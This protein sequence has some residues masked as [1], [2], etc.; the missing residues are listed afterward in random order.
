MTSTSSKDQV[1]ALISRGVELYG[2]GRLKEAIGEW[3]RAL[4][5]RPGEREAREYLKYVR[6][7]FDA[8]KS[9]FDGGHAVPLSPPKSPTERLFEEME[10]EPSRGTLEIGSG[11]LGGVDDMTLEPPSGAVDLLDLGEPGE[12]LGGSAP[13]RAK[14]PS[15]GSVSDFDVSDADGRETFDLSEME[16]APSLSASEEDQAVTVQRPS[17][18][19]FGDMA[20]TG[21]DEEP[22]TVQR[23][24]PFDMPGPAV[25]GEGIDLEM[26][27]RGAKKGFPIE[28]MK[29]TEYSDP[30]PIDIGLEPLGAAEQLSP[31]DAMRRDL[32]EE[33]DAGGRDGE[34]ED[35][36]IHRRVSN[37][38][39]R[40]LAEKVRGRGQ[41]AVVAANLALDEAP[42]S[43]VAQKVIHEHKGQLQSVFSN[44]IGNLTMVPMLAKRLDQLGAGIDSRD[45]FLLT[46]VDGLLSF[47][48]I[49]DISGMPALDAYR[50]LCRL[51]IDGI[52]H[53]S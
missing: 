40:A 3:E 34:S 39:A 53:I 14:R 16:L 5:I 7:N 51:L 31:V 32:L 42:S 24:A 47:S 41:V 46:R 23:P 26:P 11:L 6:E 1:A 30:P 4:A 25:I 15:R 12:P 28:E 36:V 8:L 45:A 20:L 9:Q 17:P 44:Y 43:V 10:P 48:D 37:L 49:I 2:A 27:A 35:D 19:D 38:V 13:R 22:V 52:I 29:T 18:I 21:D 50:I 33:A